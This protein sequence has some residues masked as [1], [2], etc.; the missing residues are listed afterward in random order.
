MTYKNYYKYLHKRSVSIIHPSYRKQLSTP[1]LL[2]IIKLKLRL[3][4]FFFEKKRG[5]ILRLGLMGCPST[6]CFN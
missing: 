1:N 3:I 5:I 4:P 2:K 6:F